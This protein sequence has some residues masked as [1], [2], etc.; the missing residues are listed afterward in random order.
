M[1]K[2]RVVIAVITVFIGLVT[3]N[4]QAAD[5]TARAPGYA[6]ELDKYV[7][8]T[9]ASAVPG[10]ALIIV[11]NGKVQLVKAYGVREVG[12]R[13]AVAP[14][15]VFRLASV[16]KTF[17][18]SAIALLVKDG[19]VG[20]DTPIQPRLDYIKFKNPTY[21]RQITLKHLLSHTTGLIAH[22]Y[23]NLLD[24]NVPYNQILKRLQDVDFACAPGTCY[25]YQNLVFSLTADIVKSY[26]GNS[27]E[28]YVASNIFAPLHMNNAS[29]GLQSFVSSPN[30]AVPH[31]K[32]KNKW[33]P[34]EVTQGYYDVAPAAGVN[35]SILDMGQWILAQLGH[36][37]EV[38]PE[39]TLA[40]LHTRVV[41]TTPS[42]AH[43]GQKESIGNVHYG[44]GWRIF[45][46]GN[47]KDVVHHSGWV[48]GFRSE[49]VL[50]RDSQ[51]G[52]A[53][54]TNA[55]PKKANEVV[56]KFLEIYEKYKQKN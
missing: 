54:L 29:Y 34:A 43:Y 14:D 47:Y 2:N 50:N 5:D 18:S 45:D 19:V 38:F 23:T 42:Q 21:G 31:V 11:A 1:V 32:R 25:G 35:A 10:A 27:Y 24:D 26:T 16:S 12:S 44:L 30:H 39:S 28:D 53:F 33:V 13:E 3:M 48:K 46:Y 40:A 49:I 7:T 6:I 8:E 56:F 15:T 55:E 52:M 4:I 22:A 17:A 41:K 9:L 36:M 20:W 51:I 37:P